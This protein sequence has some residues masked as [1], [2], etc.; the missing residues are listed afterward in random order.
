MNKKLATQGAVD[1]LEGLLSFVIRN[2]AHAVA[3]CLVNKYGTIDLIVSARDEDLLSIPGMTRS[4]LLLLKV[5][6]ALTSRRITES[7]EFGRAWTEAEIIDYLIGLYHGVS[8]ETVYM[9]I[10][11]RAD[12]V[13]ACEYMGEG[14]VSASDVYPR[15]LLETAVKNRASAVIL[16]HNHPRGL[17]KPSKDDLQSTQKLDRLFKNT[18]IELRRHYIVS[19]RDVGHVELLEEIQ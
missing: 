10:I 7:V 3:E 8:V 12:R 14:T 1:Y 18:G 11:D 9:L 16:A 6:S 4:A 15:R 5:T 17:G 2:D 13:V 19:E